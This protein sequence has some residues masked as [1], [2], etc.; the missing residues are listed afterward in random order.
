MATR[1][2]IWLSLAAVA[3]P[4][5][6]AS[7][8]EA[9]PE[10]RVEVKAARSPS[11]DGLV[12]VKAYN[13]SAVERCIPMDSVQRPRSEATSIRVWHNG[14]R[15]PRPPEGYILPQLP[16]YHRLAPGESITFK[17]DVRRRLQTLSISGDSSVDVSVGLAS[18]DCSALGANLE[19]VS[20]SRRLAFRNT[21]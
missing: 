4:A 12:Q 6:C 7:V 18:W 15:V 10:I 14:R 2:A 5:G 19:S 20:W 13:L 17:V 16:G 21:Y 1:P 3:V 11:S 9:E 8:P